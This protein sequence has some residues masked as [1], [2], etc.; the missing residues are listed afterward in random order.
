MADVATTL[1]VATK[2]ASMTASTRV[3]V[4]GV[5]VA[6][7]LGSIPDAVREVVGEDSRVRVAGTSPQVLDMGRGGTWGSTAGWTGKK[8]TRSRRC[9]SACQ[10]KGSGGWHSS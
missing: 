4:L 10:R 7:V 2:P 3:V 8:E 5:L 6:A 9:G 1:L